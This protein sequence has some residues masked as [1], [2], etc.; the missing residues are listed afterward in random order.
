MDFTVTIAAPD[1]QFYT[2][3]YK[4]EDAQFQVTDAGVLV[5]LDSRRNSKFTYGI[6]MWHSVREDVPPSVVL[7]GSA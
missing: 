3:D 2:D 4:A 1:G 5:I 6:G 7:P